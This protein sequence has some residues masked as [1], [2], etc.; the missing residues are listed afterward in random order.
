MALSDVPPRADRH[1]L[2]RKKMRQYYAIV[3][4]WQHTC[5]R[6]GQIC[7]YGAKTFEITRVSVKPLGQRIWKVKA[8]LKVYSF[9]LEFKDVFHLWNVVSL[10]CKHGTTFE[11]M[12]LRLDL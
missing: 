1:Q 2:W 3:M 7:E 9:T 6:V 10:S 8:L 12:F 11:E 5:V 4:H